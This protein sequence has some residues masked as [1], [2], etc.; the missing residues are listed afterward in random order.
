MAS[1]KTGVTDSVVAFEDELNSIVKEYLEFCNYGRTVNSFDT[2][3]KER[4]KI[5]KSRPRPQWNKQKLDIQSD[6]LN[7]FQLGA[8]RE[9]F[10]LWDDNVP[11]KIRNND[12]VCKKLEF[13][14]SIY[15]A[16]YPI[17]YSLITGNEPNKTKTEEAMQEFKTFL[18]T[19]GASLSQTTEFLPFYALPFVPNPAHHPSFKELFQD[20]WVPDL[21]MRLE[22]FLTLALKSHPQPKLFEIYAEYHRSHAQQIQ[23]FQQSI[24]DAEK[25]TMTYMKRYNKLQGD[26][27]N[28][29]GITAELVDSL[30]SCINGNMVTP[31]YLQTVCIKLFSSQVRESMDISRPGTAGSLLRA[32]VLPHREPSEA[33]NALPPLDYIKVKNDLIHADDRRQIFLLQALR[34][35]LTR[36]QAG[37]QRTAILSSYC[38]NDLLGCNRSGEY[39]TN[40]LGLL[41]S[42][43]EVVRQYTARLFNA[44]ASLAEGRTYLAKNSQLLPVLQETLQ[45]E[46]KDSITREN[47]LGA[48]QKLS[49]KRPLQSQMIEGGMI[50]WLVSVLVDSDALSDYTLEYS[51]ALLMNLCLRTTGKHK[52]CE[53][54]AHI[55]KVLSD[56]LGHENQEIRPYVN[57][58][59]YSILSIPVIREEAK[60]MGLEEILR[61]FLKDDNPDMS[62]QIQFIIKQLN[63]TDI[64]DEDAES[65]DEDE[66]DDE[67]EQ[68]AM[69]ADLDKAEVVKPE[70]GEIVGEQLLQTEYLGILTHNGKPKK[71]KQLDAALL[72]EPLQRPVTPG[73]RKIAVVDNTSRISTPHSH[74]NGML[75]RP[76]T[77]TGSRPVTQESRPR[78]RDSQRYSPSIRSRPSSQQPLPP[79]IRGD[80]EADKMSAVQSEEG[81]MRASNKSLSNVNGSRPVSAAEAFVSKPKLP[82]T[83]DVSSRPTSRGGLKTPPPQPRVSAS[84]PLSRPT[85]AGRQSG[86]GDGRPTSHGS[87]RPSSQGSNRPSSR[88][89]VGSRPVS[90]PGMKPPSSATSKKSS[91]SQP[92]SR[93]GSSKTK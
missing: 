16:I 65:D 73:V 35:R 70:R 71:N 24:V 11:E 48:L 12:P 13:Y 33:S 62:R 26:Y 4:G 23:G 86:N 82:R 18:E 54:A 29:I 91:S 83:P 81:K 66:D 56:L 15:F 7:M 28:L 38:S 20:S 90:Q 80:S 72:D 22:K 32:S 31:E 8:R 59:L 46:D 34:W 78:S 2:E 3:T 30:E 84:P 53:D 58:A 92:P 93:R 74:V 47:I 27:H 1:K 85:S 10:K 68:D 75:S 64:P 25:R 39:Q 57:G 61:C 45:S 89:Q 77:S 19:R 44:F 51:V 55:L 41:G 88:G 43:V 5:V 37:E 42:D 52:C 36:C 17:K 50:S 69:E 40:V 79:P 21:Q 67:E 60:A 9:F 14:I 76:A 49:L 6:I 87:I 63:S